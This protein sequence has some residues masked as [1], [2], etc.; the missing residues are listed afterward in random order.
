MWI[1]LQYKP[2]SRRNQSI[3]LFI[4]W[5]DTSSIQY[6][7]GMAFFHSC[8]K[9]PHQRHTWY[10]SL[11]TIVKPADSSWC[12][13]SA[14]SGHRVFLVIRQIHDA[15]VFTTLRR[16]QLNSLLEYTD[17]YITCMHT[18]THTHTHTPPHTHTHIPD[19]S[20]TMQSGATTLS[21]IRWMQPDCHSKGL[22]NHSDSAT[23]RS[24]DKTMK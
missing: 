1:F 23:S 2:Q 14:Q 9:N 19:C 22:D 15:R 24:R 6:G 21:I 8:D 3:M 20:Y 18:V 13:L 11:P 5:L 10:G 12:Q 7:C 17:T 16:W 4:T